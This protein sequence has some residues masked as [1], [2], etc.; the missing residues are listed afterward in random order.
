VTVV[1]SR[2]GGIPEVVVDGET[3]RLVP[4]GN[5]EALAAAME[6]LL[7]SGE[8]RREMG[9][10]AHA[11]AVAYFSRD[12]QIGKMAEIFRRRIGS[13]ADQPGSGAT[14]IGTR[15]RAIL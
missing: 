14:D 8:M 15:A 7:G 12:A 5:S 9:Q 6:E 10:K 1:A 2:V 13:V 4:P 11:R 3:G